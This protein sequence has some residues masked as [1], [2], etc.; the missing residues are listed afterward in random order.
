MG[1]FNLD[2]E[3]NEQ[4]MKDWTFGGTIRTSITNGFYWAERDYY[5]PSGEVQQGTEDT[6]DCASRSPVNK[7]EM[8]F[9]WLLKKKQ[10]LPEVENW[11]RKNGYITKQGGVEFS[12]AFIAIK[13]GTD[14]NGNSLKAPLEAIRVHG[15]IPKSQLPLLPTMSF[16]DYHDPNRITSKMET[17]GKEFLKIFTINYERINEPDFPTMLRVDA[18]CVAGYAW[19]EPV[20]GEY[21]RVSDS[22]NH[23]FLLFDLPYAYAFDNYFDDGKEGDF[24]KKL[25]HNF[26]YFQHGYRIY[27]TSQNPINISQ[28]SLIQRFWNFIS[29]FKLQPA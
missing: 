25:V 14:R 6:M 16:D 15:L 27:I 11:L 7:L 3:F 23:A 9:N 21:P 4:S 28:P 10:L 24:V 22:P 20:D 8:D 17:L 1:H 5:L 18:L 29:I 2:R 26:S 12:D 13:S 19:P